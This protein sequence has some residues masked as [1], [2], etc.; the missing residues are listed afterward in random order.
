[1]HVSHFVVPTGRLLPAQRPQL[2]FAIRE[3]QIAQI[4]DDKGVTH[5]D[6]RSTCH[7]C[8]GTGRFV[9]VAPSAPSTT[10]QMFPGH[11]D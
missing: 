5:S 8:Y 3:E 6:N 9:E 10:K 7:Q 2:L 1:M 11:V 4:E